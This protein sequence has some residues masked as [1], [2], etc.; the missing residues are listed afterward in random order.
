M[1]FILSFSFLFFFRIFV[2]FFFENFI[3]SSDL[4]VLPKAVVYGTDANAIAVAN[5]IKI[6]SPPRFRVVAFLDKSKSNKSKSIL[7]LPIIYNSKKASVLLRS[8]KANTLIIAEKSL[9]KEEKLS[10]IDDCLEYNI[11]VFTIPII[12]NWENE[13]E[14]SKQIKSFQIEDLLQRKPIVLDNKLVSSQLTGKTVL[15]TGAAGSI[16]SEIVWQVLEFLPKRVIM[17]DQAETPLHHLSLEISKANKK[18]KVLALISDIRNK[19]SLEEIFKKYQPQIVFHAAAYKHVPLMEENPTQ[20]I[21][22]NVLGTKN[23]ADLA[24]LY[25]AKKFVMVSTDK[26]VNPS[27]VMGASKRI[28]EKYVQSLHYHGKNEQIQ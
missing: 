9:T 3:N 22:T 28:A 12:T 18:V 21:F 16:G 25:Q 15:I 2:K 1:S 14:I 24:V 10:L 19:K 27:N 6:E 26:A 8:Y 13:K 5:A 23:V 7:G 4:K 11:K 20:A 17:I